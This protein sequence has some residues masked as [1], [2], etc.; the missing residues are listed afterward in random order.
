MFHRNLN[1]LSVVLLFA[2][3]GGGDFS[4]AGLE[5]GGVGPEGTGGAVEADAGAAGAKQGT[6]GV[7]G[8]TGGQ[9]AVTGGSAGIGADTGGTAGGGTG[10]QQA[11]SGGDP[12][13]PGGGATGGQQAS[14]GGLGGGTG[15][16]PGTGGAQSSGGV[17]TGGVAGCQPPYADQLT[18]A[19]LAALPPSITWTAFYSYV[20]T[21]TC[22]AYA[23]CGPLGGSTPTPNCGELF[24]RWNSADIRPGGDVYISFSAQV[25]TAARYGCSG[26]IINSCSIEAATTQG[27]VKVHIEN[28]AGAPALAWKLTAPQSFTT[29]NATSSCP[30][31]DGTAAGTDLN[32][33]LLAA[34]PVT[35]TGSCQ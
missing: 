17:G 20:S 6:G 3:C 10:G 13:G 23:A 1:V 7:T 4:T 15:G 12:V 21:T 25:N 24:I 29:W 30:N 35:L 2:G 34:I 27:T 31:F 26:A 33:E 18:T 28:T 32:A 14:T 16:S 8:V 22:P 19:L 9:A 11:G 5:T